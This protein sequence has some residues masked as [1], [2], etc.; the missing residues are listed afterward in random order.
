MLVIGDGKS[1]MCVAS[2]ADFVFA[3]GSLAEYCI[4]N[5]IPH[6]RFD[7]FAQLPALLAQLPQSVAANATAFTT[8]DLFIE[9]QELLHHV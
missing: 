4:A 6:A 9:N 3:K 5:R 7:C 8:A 1:D 2:T